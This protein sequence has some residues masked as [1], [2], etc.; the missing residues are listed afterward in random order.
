[1][2]ANPQYSGRWQAL[3]ESINPATGAITAKKTEDIILKSTGTTLR[4]T[5]SKK[6]F[7]QGVFASNDIVAFRKV[8]P[9]PK[10]PEFASFPGS[11]ISVEQNLLGQVTFRDNDKFTAIFLLQSR[12]PL[13]S[14]T[15][16][17]LRYTANR[18]AL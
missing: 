6:Q 18:V 5:D 17:L 11:D 9:K 8:V 1:M 16:K 15:Q 10:R 14:Q 7:M 12:T 4:I 3:I 2:A 13:G